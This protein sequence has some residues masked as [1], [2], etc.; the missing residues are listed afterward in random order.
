MSE[1]GPFYSTFIDPLLTTMRK[2]VALEIKPNEQIIDVACGT[3]AQAFVLSETAAK[4]TGVDLS[5]SMITH[6]KSTSLK[7]KITNAEFFIYDAT[8]LKSFKNKKFDIA[9]MSLALHQFSPDLHAPILSEMKRIANKIIL[10]DYNVPLPK[11]YTGFGSRVAEFLA[12]KEHNKNFKSF[13]K[14]GGLNEIL[15]NNNLKIEKS[16][17]MGKGAFQMVVCS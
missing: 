8:D 2:R 9:I 14:L 10:V 1:S 16:K 7:K 12:G 3:G 15:E 5:E 17:L 13:Y 6:A 4:V 11:N